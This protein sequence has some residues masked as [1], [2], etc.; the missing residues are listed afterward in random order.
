MV[1]ESWTER[2]TARWRRPCANDDGSRGR[3][4]ATGN[5]AAADRSQY[6]DGESL[7]SI[8]PLVLTLRSFSLA[9]SL[10]MA[11]SSSSSSSPPLGGDFDFAIVGAGVVGSALAFSLARSGRKVALVERDLSHPDRIVGELL[12]PGGVKALT[13]LGMQDCLE[14]IDAVP[15]EGYQV[16]YGPRAVPIPYPEESGRYGGKGIESTSGE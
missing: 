11:A 1:M 3:R 8:H 10:I 9:R 14:N 15:V 12:Q 6:G 4:N 2:N 7:N 16:F 5:G 13:W